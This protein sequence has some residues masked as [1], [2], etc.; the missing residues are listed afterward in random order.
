MGGTTLF[1]L[2][3]YVPLNRVWFSRSGVLKGKSHELCTCEPKLDACRGFRIP[4]VLK[5]GFALNLE[6]VTVKGQLQMNLYE[7]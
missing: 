4:G 7:A 6:G 5:R 2:E 3:G 1:G